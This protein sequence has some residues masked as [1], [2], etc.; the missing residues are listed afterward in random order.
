[1]DMNGK[2]DPFL[3]LK[4]RNRGTHKQTSTKQKTLDPIWNE[5]FSLE[6]VGERCF[7]FASA[8]V[9]DVDIAMPKKKIKSEQQRKNC[10]VLVFLLVYWRWFRV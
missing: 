10:I 2:S 7:Y 4:V 1:M 5:E 3:Q 8:H 9:Y 6:V